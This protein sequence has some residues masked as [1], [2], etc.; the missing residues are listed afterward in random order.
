MNVSVPMLLFSAL[1]VSPLAWMVVTG[2]MSG[3]R[4]QLRAGLALFGA[5]AL[6]VL[7]WR[8]HAKGKLFPNRCGTC[9]SG[10]VRVKPGELRP[11]AGQ[12]APNI[13]WRCMR[14]GRLS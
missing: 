5:A 1:L 10:M 6:L 2:D 14:C 11:P 13:R 7:A 4:G 8:S 12:P 9:K 3:S